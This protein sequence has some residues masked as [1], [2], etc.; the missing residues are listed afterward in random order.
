MIKHASTAELQEDPGQ[1]AFY[2]GGR[3]ACHRQRAADQAPT[4]SL[5]RTNP[6]EQRCGTARSVAPA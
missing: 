5:R 6:G 3:H 2:A 1:R 4:L